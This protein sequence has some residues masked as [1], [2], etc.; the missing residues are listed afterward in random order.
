[1]QS[2]NSQ[3]TIIITPQRR[4]LS[5]DVLPLSILFRGLRQKESQL[6]SDKTLSLL[7]CSLMHTRTDMRNAFQRWTFLC[8]GFISWKQNQNLCI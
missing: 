8:K 1:M 2:I 3:A 7:D 4:Q 6:S 5:H